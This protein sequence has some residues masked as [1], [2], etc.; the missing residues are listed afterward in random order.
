MTK[1][2]LVGILAAI[3][4]TAC[5]GEGTNEAAEMNNLIEP[6]ENA[7]LNAAENAVETVDNTMEPS[8]GLEPAE[9]SRPATADRTP[10]AENPRTKQP[11]ARQPQPKA[12]PDPHAGHDM[13]N[14][15]NMQH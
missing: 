11:P 4:V 7:V 8:A 6:V 12:E 9:E 3:S 2:L 1:K 10:R 14:M 15:A 5:N 13:G